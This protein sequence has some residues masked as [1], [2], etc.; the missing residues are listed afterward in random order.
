MWK[1]SNGY[2]YHNRKSLGTKDRQEAK[3]RMNLLKKKNWMEKHGLI[4]INTITNKTIGNLLQEYKTFKELTGKRTD[5][6]N[7][8][9][10]HLNPIRFIPITKLK[11]SD[12]E[13]YL[14]H[15][16]KNTQ[17]SYYLEL[18]VCANYGIEKDYLS[19]NFIKAKGKVGSRLVIASVTEIWLLYRNVLK[20]LNRFPMAKNNRFDLLIQLALKSG[21]RQSELLNYIVWNTD[22]IGVNGKTD[23]REIPYENPMFNLYKFKGL[24][25]EMTRTYVGQ[26]FKRF[27]RDSA[28]NQK[29]CFETLRHT[30]GTWMVQKAGIYVTSQLMGHKKLETTKN[31]LHMDITNLKKE[32]K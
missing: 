19:H 21:L 24:Q 18:S 16:S 7:S 13:P 25:F 4:T 5:K 6:I 22:T 23:Y 30:F 15:L 17:N 20:N 3:G 28:I 12:I 9:I 27:V 8:L 14:S 26:T 11:Q 1:N 2:W 32:I 31:Y 29:I 10:K